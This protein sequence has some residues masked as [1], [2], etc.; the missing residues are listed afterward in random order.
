SGPYEGRGPK[1]RVAEVAFVTAL[2]AGSLGLGLG[3]PDQVANGAFAVLLS[4]PL[5]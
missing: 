2:A 3:T 5:R 1:E 4:I